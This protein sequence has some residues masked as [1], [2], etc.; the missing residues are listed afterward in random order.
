MNAWIPRIRHAIAGGSRWAVP[1]VVVLLMGGCQIT[2]AQSPLRET[3]RIPAAVVERAETRVTRI[4]TRNAMAPLHVRSLV[5]PEDRLDEEDWEAFSELLRIGKEVCRL[6]AITVDVW[7]GMVEAKGDAAPGNAPGQPTF[8]WSYYDRVVEC[9]EERGLQWVP[10]LSLHSCGNNVGDNGVFIP[11]PPWLWDWLVQQSPDGK[12]S[13]EDLRYTSGSGRTCP[14]YVSL[15]ADDLVVPQYRQFMEA[16]RDHFGSDRIQEVNISCGPSGE[17]RYP[18]YNRYDGGDF[19]KYGLLQC[20]GRMAREDC[21]TQTG[22]YPPEGTDGFLSSGQYAQPDGK[23]FL[24]WYQHRLLEHGARLM[25]LAN[26]VFSTR[27]YATVPLGLKIP[28]IHWQT[29]V[30]AEGEPLRL[31]RFPEIVAGLST[32]DSCEQGVR[33]YSDLLGFLA[34][35]LPERAVPYILHFTCVEKPNLYAD[36]REGHSMAADLVEWVR[37]AA[38]A[39]PIRSRIL[40]KAENALSGGIYSPTQ[41]RRICETTGRDPFSGMT[42]LRLQDLAN[43]CGSAQWL[44]RV[45]RMDEAQGAAALDSTPKH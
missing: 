39:D 7:W 15:W 45:G 37:R 21:R 31:R 5:L 40:L 6:D 19:P 26:E 33:S 16:F 30:S 35:Q 20:A 22:K 9:I 42:F 4:F 44:Q 36:P 29:R 28:G 11:L 32:E 23:R 1:P 2:I 43:V 34:E 8:D 3:G 14:E 18:T 24:Q 13:M 38:A 10:I 12:A 41:A 17:L 27:G 25:G